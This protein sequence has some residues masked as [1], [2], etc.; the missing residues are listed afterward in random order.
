MEQH[1]ESDEPIEISIERGGF[2]LGFSMD[3]TRSK[4]ATSISSND[5]KGCITF[6]QD[7]FERDSAE[8]LR[9]QFKQCEAHLIVVNNL[10]DFESNLLEYFIEGKRDVELLIPLAPNL[11]ARMITFMKPFLNLYMF[12]TA[13]KTVNSV[14][15]DD[16]AVSELTAT[17]YEMCASCIQRIHKRFN[18]LSAATSPETLSYLRKCVEALQSIEQRYRSIQNIVCNQSRMHR[19]INQIMNPFKDLSD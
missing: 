14:I 15:Q 10:L 1:S 13:R 9:E 12:L 2:V 11:Y 8:Y 5:I 18:D 3:A 6:D 17:I 4:I 16:I 7:A 19:R